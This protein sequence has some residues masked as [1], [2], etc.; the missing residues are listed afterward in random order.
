[1]VKSFQ[2]VEKIC[3]SISKYSIYVLLA[4]MPVL[5]LPWTSDA[6]EFNKQ[7]ALI[8]L[9]FISLFFWMVKALVSGKFLANLN[10]THIAVSLVFLAGLLSTIFSQNR[11]GSF[12]GWPSPTGEALI[13]IIGLTILYFV[14]SNTFSKK[15]IINSI[16][17]SSIAGGLAVLFG[18]LQL[19]GL[20]IVPFGFLKSAS[21]NTIGSVGSLGIFIAVFLPL[22]TVLIVLTEKWLRIIFS[23]ILGLCA[24]SLVLINYPIVWW[25]VLA[26]SILLVVFGVFK[27]DLF[28]LRWL[29]ISMFFLVLSLFFIILHPQINVASRSI[30]VYLN[31]SSTLDVALKAVKQ[32]PIV[33]SGLGTFAN[34]FSKFKKIDFNN[35]QLWNLKF[36][37]GG[38]EVLNTLATSGFLG[39]IALFSLMCVVIFYGIKSLF[40]SDINNKKNGEYIYIL[41][42]GI[43]ASVVAICVAF[44]LYATSLYIYVFFFFLIACVIGLISENKEYQLSPSSFLTLGVTFVFT[45]FFIFGLGLL[46]LDGQ[47]YVAEINY[48]QG[49]TTNS[50]DKMIASLEKAVTLN[51]SMDIYLNDLALVYLSQISDVA[52]QKNL[53]DTDKSNKVSA[54]V[55]NAINASTMASSI[56]P[57]NVTNWSVRASIY[58]NLIGT[59]P[60]SEDWAIKMYD[61]AIKL[62][63]QNP[64]YVTQKGIVLLTKA[65]GTDKD[66]PDAKK[67]DLDSAKTQFDKA[68]Q[69]KS[70]YAS[71]RFQLAM[72]LQAQGKTDQVM[73]ALQEAKKYAMQ[74]VGLSFQIGLLYYQDKDYQNAQKELERTVFL[75]P[76][77]SNALYFLGLTYSAQNQNSKAI[78]AINKVLKLNPDNAE[79][80]KVLDNLNNGKDPLLGISEQ[81]PAEPPVKDV[82]PEKTKK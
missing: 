31:Q 29:S 43:L 50:K 25:V 23:V 55:S 10:K 2:I 72:V 16:I 5:F 59:V 77:Y 49:I 69:L 52:N 27:K 66:K 17:I 53:S 48:Y 60:D 65:Y 7:T 73:P 82:A 58:Q 80:K 57:N 1:M 63:P 28:D 46:I 45:L 11:Y 70:D 76:N 15:E 51:P 12:W 18:T 41:S 3:Q 8:F 4:I 68:I 34:D 22:L 9:V 81:V 24:I 26:S 74:D 61:E 14:I 56:N 19:L 54:L 13:T 78:D 21:F 6:L 67:Q 47:R 71:A 40:L 20:F 42:G 75:N 62:D 32:S 79:I 36:D 33:G 35:S 37:K 30:E 39:I 64:Y 44:F 38:S